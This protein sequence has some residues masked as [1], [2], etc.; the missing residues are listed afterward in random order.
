MLVVGDGVTLSAGA[1][2]VSISG[3]VVSLERGGEMVDV[4]GTGRFALSTLTPLVNGSNGSESDN[5]QVFTGGQGRGFSAFSLPLLLLLLC[6]IWGV[7]MFAGVG[8]M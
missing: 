1:S 2:G 3:T 8:V 4:D 5:V 6:G 7:V